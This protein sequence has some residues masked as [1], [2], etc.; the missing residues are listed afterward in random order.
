M[1]VLATETEW[2]D[3][4]RRRARRRRHRHRIDPLRLVCIDEIWVKTNMAPLRGWGPKG[5]RL[6]GRAPHGHWRTMTFVRAL[7]ADRIDAPCVF[8]GRSLARPCRAGAR[9]D[10]APGRCGDHGQSRQPQGHRRAKGHPRGGCS[11][12]V[13]A[14]IQPRSEPDRTGLRQVQASH[15]QRVRK[16][17]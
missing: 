4:A 3:I 6:P 8:D 5:A 9:P 7:R 16:N 15:A 17:R 2:P 10:P 13:P 1:T 12:A 14:T 11:P